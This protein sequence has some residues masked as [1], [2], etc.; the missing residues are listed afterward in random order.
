MR[1]LS[2]SLS[3]RNSAPVNG[4]MNGT[5]GLR[6]YRRGRTRRGGAHFADEGE[7]LFLFN[8]S[9]G[10]DDGGFRFVGVIKVT[11]RKEPSIDASLLVYLM[12]RRLNTQ[13]HIPSQ[14]LGRAAESSGLSEKDPLS[15]NTGVRSSGALSPF[16]VIPAQAGISGR[17]QGFVGGK[18][19]RLLNG[20]TW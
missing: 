11:K 20:G 19:S 9:L 6:G 8:Q 4:A 1:M 18:G 17:G 3:R 2:H 15:R 14:L 16:P 7:N 13:P 12:K 5:S 10:V